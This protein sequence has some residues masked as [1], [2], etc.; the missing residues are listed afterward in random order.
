MAKE[1]K[2]RDRPLVDPCPE[3]KTE[4]HS[5]LPSYGNCQTCLKARMDYLDNLPKLPRGSSG[6]GYDGCTP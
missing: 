1:R 2:P 6:D 5:I 3:C 4:H